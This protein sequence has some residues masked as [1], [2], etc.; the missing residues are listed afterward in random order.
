MQV[1]ALVKRGAEQPSWCDMKS[2]PG[3]WPVLNDPTKPPWCQAIMLSLVPACIPNK[4]K[5]NTS[6][7]SRKITVKMHLLSGFLESS[8]FRADLVFDSL[9][10][11]VQRD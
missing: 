10:L 2:K 4:S 8:Y 9:T 11:G 1:W 6:N 5:Q 7:A 3:T